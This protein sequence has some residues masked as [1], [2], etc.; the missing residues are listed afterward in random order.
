MSHVLSAALILSLST[1]AVP[2][3]QDLAPSEI[4]YL[5]VKKD[6]GKDC[7]PLLRNW[8]P[9][10]KE[11]VGKS[12]SKVFV[13]VEGEKFGSVLRIHVRTHPARVVVGVKTFRTKRGCRFSPRITA[14]AKTWL[15][16]MMTEALVAAGIVAPPPKRAE[17]PKLSPNVPISP[18]RPDAAIPSEPNPAPPAARPPTSPDSVSPSIQIGDTQPSPPRDLGLSLL[19]GVGLAQTSLR[20]LEPSSA[21]LRN[22]EL[23]AMPFVSFD[24]TYG[25]LFGKRLK[26]G[27][28][29][30][31]SYRRSLGVSS[32]RPEEASSFPTSYQDFSVG[33]G[34]F[35][36]VLEVRAQYQNSSFS[37]SESD[38]GRVESELPGL[39]YSSVKTGLKITAPLSRNLKVFVNADFLLSMGMQS[40]FNASTEIDGVR[41]LEIEGGL[42]VGLIEKLGLVLCLRYVR[43]EIVFSSDV[44]AD[45]LQDKL[46]GGTLFVSFRP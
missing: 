13:S 29:L 41:G 3:R 37:L 25:P 34:G 15:N 36:S 33:V 1:L 39:Q 46:L 43:R 19:W 26:Y 5:G 23:D 31:G 4:L 35:V 38:D 44:P 42:F 40:K 20:Y 11:I 30:L 18:S 12:N 8:L 2:A 16:R 27:P 10:E 32:K 17:A 9:S 14:L 24:V 6:I 22:Y 21:A 7:E 28:M 45:S